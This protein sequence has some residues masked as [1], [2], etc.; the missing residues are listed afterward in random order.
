MTTK[1]NASNA[2][3]AHDTTEE[4][5]SS[6]M[7]S[8]SDLAPEPPKPGDIVEGSVIALDRAR[9][10]IDLPPF[11]TGVIFGREYMNAREVIKR[12]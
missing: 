3:L 6:V 5:V 8:F 7:Q 12:I 10:Y 2:A 9:L 11:G 1:K 4:V